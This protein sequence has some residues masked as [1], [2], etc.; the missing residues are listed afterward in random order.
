MSDDAVVESQSLNFLDSRPVIYQFN[1]LLSDYPAPFQ[2][3]APL[4]V[5]SVVNESLSLLPKDS[6]E[7]RG[8]TGIDHIPPE[9]EQLNA[10]SSNKLFT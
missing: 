2:S 8:E 1:K 6:V 7:T 9:T 4:H 10:I 5:T 3:I